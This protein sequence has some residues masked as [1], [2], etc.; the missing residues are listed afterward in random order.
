MAR[1][2]EDPVRDRPDLD[3]YPELAAGYS[4]RQLI[5]SAA[6]GTVLMALGGALYRLASDD[7][8]RKAMAAP[9]RDGRPRLPPGQRVIEKLRP[10][11]GEEGPG[12]VRSFRLRVHGLVK[13][14][15][16]LDYATPHG[17]RDGLNPAR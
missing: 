5:Q 11:G 15:L 3:R 8:T 12:D 2:E 9:R 13:S 1:V 6:A 16:V 10:M 17:Y 7:L 4:R 14:E